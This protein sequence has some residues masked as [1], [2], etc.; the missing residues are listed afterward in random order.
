MGHGPVSPAMGKP[1]MLTMVV[2]A[3]DPARRS[4]AGDDPSSWFNV[5]HV[6]V[7]LRALLFVQGAIAI[8]VGLV[9]ATP[10]A[11]LQTFSSASLAA[12]PALLAWLVGAC[13]ARPIARYWPLRAQA[14]SALVWGGLCATAGL[15]LR[16]WALAEPVAALPLAAAF[17]GGVATASLMVAWLRL[18]ARAQTPADAHARLAQLQQ[19]IRPHFLFN[20]L[21]TAVALVREDPARAEGVLEDLAELFRTALAL[22]RDPRASVTLDDEV[23]LARRY[24]EIEQL[25]FGERL[26]VQ[27]QLDPSAGRARL[28]ALLL[29][30]LVENAVRH[31]VEPAEGGATVRITSEVERG[32]VRLSV[33]NSLGDAAS[34]PGSGMAL[35]N[36]RERLHLLHDVTAAFEAGREEGSGGAEFRV[37]LRLPLPS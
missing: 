32:E 17:A 16:A 22:D 25:R 34:Q 14:V 5:C 10:A 36:V 28:P 11:W 4:D 30:P 29:Q 3:P 1:T 6:G 33:V 15:A 7:V 26:R 9:S 2:A 19:S 8:A 35:A 37:R 27:W 21:N 31:G 18:R 20:T 12:I 23:A 24:L 13:G